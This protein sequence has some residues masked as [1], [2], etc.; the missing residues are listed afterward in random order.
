M[1]DSILL[2]LSQGKN[3]FVFSVLGAAYDQLQR[4]C[5]WR[6]AKMPRV[7]RLP[8]RQSLGPD[9]DT[10]ELGGTIITERSGYGTLTDLRTLMAKGEPVLLCDSQGNIH[11][12]W[13]MESLQETQTAIHIDGLPRKQT[14][15]LRLSVYGE[16]AA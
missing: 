4:S 10:I 11:G 2:A 16:D 13:C 8:A 15:L 3:H 1:A 9:D 14:F 5:A 12:K 7:G 6:W